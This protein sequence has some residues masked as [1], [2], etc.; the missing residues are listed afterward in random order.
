MNNNIPVNPVTYFIN[1]ND[2]ESFT[3]EGG[4]IL[5]SVYYHPICILLFADSIDHAKNVV[6]RMLEFKRDC[7][8]KSLEVQ[9]NKPILYKEAY[10]HDF[11]NAESMIKKIDKFE[12]KEALKNQV[13]KTAWAL[14]D[15]I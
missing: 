13:Y 9:F 5:Y 14:N 7:A 6:K 2:T 3:Y 15:T 11:N 4:S 10:T 1:G 12:I 8:S